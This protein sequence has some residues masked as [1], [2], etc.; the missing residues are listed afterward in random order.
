MTSALDAGGGG[1][2][3]DCEFQEAR[4]KWV[5]DTLVA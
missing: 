3:W 2:Y 5:R 4:Y 1:G